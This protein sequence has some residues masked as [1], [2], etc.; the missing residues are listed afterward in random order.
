MPSVG[1]LE[2]RV[3]SVV[4]DRRRPGG[5]PTR[6]RNA[7]RP[8][9]TAC[10]AEKTDD[11]HD[12]G[13][14]Q[15]ANGLANGAPGVRPLRARAHAESDAFR[16]RSEQTHAENHRGDEHQHGRDRAKPS[17]A[18]HSRSWTAKRRGTACQPPARN[19]MQK[20]PH[21]RPVGQNDARSSVL[22]A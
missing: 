6:A 12:C 9:V 17:E 19:T 20:K 2:R 4:G 21:R 22:S 8:S 7:C 14:T 13:A 18:A 1:E 5:G 15:C 16:Q 3:G 11:E 10:V